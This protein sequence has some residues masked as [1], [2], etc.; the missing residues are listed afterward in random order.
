MDHVLEPDHAPT[1][2]RQVK[3]CSGKEH[4]THRE[5][6]GLMLYHCNCGY[7]SGWLPEEMLPDANEFSRDHR[8]SWAGSF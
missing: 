7:S 6:T 5:L 1:I 8:P 4:A 3:S 2:V